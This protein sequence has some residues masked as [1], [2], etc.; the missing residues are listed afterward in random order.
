MSQTYNLGKVAPTP[1]GAYSITAQYAPLDIITYNGSSYMVLQSVTGVTPPNATYYQLIASKG[2]AGASGS[3]ATISAG[4]VTML[5]YGSTPTATNVGT[6]NAAVFNFGIP[7]SPVSDGSVGY[8]KLDSTM[9]NLLGDLENIVA[10][11]F[12]T[13]INYSAGDYVIY[14][15]NNT[16]PALYRFTESKS[17]GAWNGSVVQQVA[18]CNDLKG[19]IDKTAFLNAG[20]TGTAYTST[21][22]ETTV[23]T[24]LSSYHPNPLATLSSTSDLLS[25]GQYY[26][27][28]V[29]GTEYVLP[30]QEW[31]VNTI[32]GTTVST[33]GFEFV[34]NLSYWGDSSGFYDNVNNVP[35][36]IADLKMTDDN[37]FSEGLY[38]F[39][40]TA[41]SVTVKIEKITYSGT[42]IPRW[43]LYGY[44]CLPAYQVIGGSSNHSFNVGQNNFQNKSA[45]IGIGQGNTISNSGCLAIGTANTVSGQGAQAIGFRGVSSGKFSQAMGYRST[46][47]GNYSH[48]NGFQCTASATGASADG[49]Q[50]TASGQYSTTNGSFTTAN[51]RSQFVFGEFNV[52][53]PSSNTAGKRGNYVEIVGNGA[54][55]SN[56][57][58][59][60]T[61]DWNGNE[62]L[63]GSLTLGM[64]TASEVTIT[65]AQLA[66]LLALLN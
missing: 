13:S 8:G 21:L 49:Y 3:P 32:S 60:R 50:S 27:V 25:F 64:G 51:H 12:S 4:S 57:A 18:A 26:R 37:S 20:I 7:Y 42:I 40:S 48:T 47:S 22:A 45:N 6:A 2:D 16:S 66:Q 31:Y 46:A 28:T 61:L 23:T 11:E 36:L 56:R 41:S 63:A 58:N 54:D 35:F 17:A 34:G 1:R 9:K 44:G 30:S 65:A 52:A 39:T 29:N 55:D 53:D 19:K 62:G 43:L 14:N 10:D 5:A 38:V 15:P 59:A 33:K 24:S